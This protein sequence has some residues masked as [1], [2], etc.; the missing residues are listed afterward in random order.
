[1]RTHTRESE[2]FMVYCV[3]VFELLQFQFGAL[4]SFF[5]LARF[6][7]GFLIAFFSAPSRTKHCNNCCCYYWNMY[8][9]HFG[10]CSFPFQWFFLCLNNA[11]E[12]ANVFIVDL[13]VAVPF[14]YGGSF[15]SFGY[16]WQL[17]A[18]VISWGCWATS[19][20]LLLSRCC[21]SPRIWSERTS[22]WQHDKRQNKPFK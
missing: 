2:L 14:K 20:I 10:R 11:F 17:C 15:A 1:M 13:F 18:R 3:C 5:P 7:L 12:W 16:R 8:S 6:F 22:F 9:V 21:H 4:C 19:P